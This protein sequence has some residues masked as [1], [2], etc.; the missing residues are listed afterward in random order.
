MSDI[1]KMIEF[2]KISKKENERATEFNKMQNMTNQPIERF[3]VNMFY[4]Y[5]KIS[6]F[7]LLFLS[8]SSVFDYFLMN[9]S[10]L[11]N[12]LLHINFVYT[13]CTGYLTLSFLFISNLYKALY[14][15]KETNE[16]IRRKMLYIH[17]FILLLTASLCTLSLLSG[18]VYGIDR[19]LA[20]MLMSPILI[21]FLWLASFNRS[22]YLE[23]H[24]KLYLI[25]KEKAKKNKYN[26]VQKIIKS[27]NKVLKHF[28]QD[29]NQLIFIESFYK[30]TTLSKLEKKI[31]KKL[32]IEVKKYHDQK[33]L[34]FKLFGENLVKV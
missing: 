23:H 27:K 7:V 4:K 14:N 32:F 19:Y 21:Y 3:E 20:S 15:I 22:K 25:R 1:E 18:Y 5:Y 17:L 33:D 10:I 28:I 6:F 31:V 11:F 2:I 8:L 16:Y 29:K 9:R 26:E 12:S 30:E 34:K 13:V 24:L